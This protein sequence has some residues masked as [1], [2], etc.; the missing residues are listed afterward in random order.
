MSHTLLKATSLA[1]VVSL[2]ACF[3]V[4][5]QEEHAGHSQG[6]VG[7]VNFPTSC[8]AAAQQQFNGA[9]AILHSFWYEEAL[10]SL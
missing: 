10:K 8:D 1:A 3:H 5:A 6:I 4:V 9:V 2:A 7:N